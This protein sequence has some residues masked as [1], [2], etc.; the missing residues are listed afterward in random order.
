[1]NDYLRGA[2][3]NNKRFKGLLS[4]YRPLFPTIHLAA[5]WKS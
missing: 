3:F 5:F 4:G 2:T 1:M